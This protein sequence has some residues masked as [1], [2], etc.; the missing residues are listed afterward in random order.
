MNEPPKPTVNVNILKRCRLGEWRV[1]ITFGKG[2]EAEKAAAITEK[3]LAEV[4]LLAQLKRNP[5]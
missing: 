1:E 3:Y 4:Y 5:Q 2:P